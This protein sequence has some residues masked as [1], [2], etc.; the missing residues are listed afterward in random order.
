LA[1]LPAQAQAKYRA[2]TSLIADT[3]ALN[4]AADQRA[5]VMRDARLCHQNTSKPKSSGK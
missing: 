1:R 2:L 5:V 3:E 4:H